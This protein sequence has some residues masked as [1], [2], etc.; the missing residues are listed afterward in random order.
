MA[1][2]V[3]PL[4]EQLEQAHD[5]ITSLVDHVFELSKLIDL[6]SNLLIAEDLSQVVQLYQ[7]LLNDLNINYYAKVFSV[8]SPAIEVYSHAV[9]AEETRLIQQMEAS[10]SILQT[11]NELVIRSEHLLLLVRGLKTKDREN[12]SRLKDLL[13]I[14]ISTL[15]RKLSLIDQ[16]QIK[17]QQQTAITDRLE[18][19]LA[20]MQTN[21]RHDHRQNHQTSIARLREFMVATNELLSNEQLDAQTYDKVSELF[22]SSLKELD[23]ALYNSLDLDG[24]VEQ[25]KQLINDLIGN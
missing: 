3:R 17:T 8:E 14:C 6:Q 7:D 1:I 25:F 13:I 20:E 2:D 22:D 16:A 12:R 5:T 24:F 19:A 15:E 18:K 11:Q 10:D 21:L 4:D 9:T 23:R